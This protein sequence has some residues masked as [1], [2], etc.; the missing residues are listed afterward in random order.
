MA[1]LAKELGVPSPIIGP[2]VATPPTQIV[3]LDSRDL[4][5]MGV[6]ISGSI[7]EQATDTNGQ[8][9]IERQ[10][11]STTLATLAPPAK[12]SMNRPSWNEFID[13]AIALSAEQNQG[14][15]N[16]V[17]S[18]K[19]ETKE[20][21]MAVSYLLKDGRQGFATALQDQNGDIKRRE[22]CGSN[23]ANDARDCF[24]WDT[25][26]KY[27][28]FRTADGHWVQGVSNLQP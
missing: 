13:K 8:P 17:R 26:A 2:M 10:A 4:G 5:S 21:F 11:M 15:A 18:C 9:D 14:T 3:W 22:V 25:G 19:A 28:D 20:C 6:K 23:G 27:R 12:P 1:R 24:D 16:L 7:R